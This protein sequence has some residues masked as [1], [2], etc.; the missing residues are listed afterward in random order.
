LAISASEFLNL[1]SMMVRTD[2]G[3]LARGGQKKPDSIS[4]FTWNIHLL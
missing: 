4:H 3:N 1:I 2:I